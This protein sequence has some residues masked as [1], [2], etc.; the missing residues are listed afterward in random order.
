[1]G[2]PVSTISFINSARRGAGR[3]SFGRLPLWLI[4]GHLELHEKASALALKAD[5]LR[6]G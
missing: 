1:M 2:N 4:S 3:R 5:I 6:S